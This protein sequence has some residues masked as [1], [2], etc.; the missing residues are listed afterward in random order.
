LS[1]PCREISVDLAG[2]I[3]RQFRIGR[4]DDLERVGRNLDARRRARFL[5]DRTGDFDDALAGD[6]QSRLDE[7]LVHL[8]FL[9][10]DLD[11]ARR[12]SKDQECD[13][14]EI[15]DLVDPAGDRRVVARLG[16]GSVGS[17]LHTTRFTQAELKRSRSHR[18][19]SFCRVSTTT[20]V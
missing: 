10:L 3:E 5:F 7:V 18:G 2:G 1:Q 9:E 16:V 6:A 20:D 11:L 14:P 4:R 13:A 17:V 8:V 15:A 12:I 19:E